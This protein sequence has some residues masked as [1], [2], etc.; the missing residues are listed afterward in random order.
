[1]LLQCVVG[2]LVWVSSV[3]ILHRV[4]HVL[5][6]L[7]A[8]SSPHP[9]LL[10]CGTCNLSFMNFSRFAW[11]DSWQSNSSVRVFVQL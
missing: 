5:M 8:K 9:L 3:H 1:M 4:Q 6:V 10:L 11:G 2:G 7:V